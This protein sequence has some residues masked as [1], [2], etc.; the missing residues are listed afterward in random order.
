MLAIAHLKSSFLQVLIATRSTGM[1]ACKQKCMHARYYS[2]ID[3]QMWLMQ[4]FVSVHAQLPMR[5]PREPVFKD[6][7]YVRCICRCVRGVVCGCIWPPS[8]YFSLVLYM[9]CCENFRS[10]SRLNRGVFACCGGRHHL[11]GDLCRLTRTER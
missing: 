4:L 11:S 7:R 5:P 10:L 2:Y 6:T 9:R 8:I 1:H 3:F